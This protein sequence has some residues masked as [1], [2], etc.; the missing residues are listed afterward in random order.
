MWVLDFVAFRHGALK[1]SRHKT[2]IASMI[3]L[4]LSIVLIVVFALRDGGTAGASLGAVFLASKALSVGEV[5]IFYLVLWALRIPD[6][7]AWR[8]L[9]FALVMATVTRA[10]ALTLGYALTPGRPWLAVVF[11]IVTVVMALQFLLR[12]DRHEDVTEHWAVRFTK[13]LLPLSDRLPPRRYVLVEDGRRKGTLLLLAA[14][15]FAFSVVVFA[16]TAF[17]AAYAVTD[18]PVI[19]LGGGLLGLVGFRSL[20]FLVAKWGDVLGAVKPA[21]TLNFG[22]AG[23]ATLA[24]PWFRIDPRVTLAVL[25]VIWATACAAVW[26]AA[27]NRPAQIRTR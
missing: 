13:G 26:Y 10:L 14:L 5:F 16:V 1:A 11:G 15:V 27:H 17:P 25:F 23:L 20:Y 7:V 24:A 6:V 2:L 19:G 3:W 22:F 18:D 4:A 12:S 9:F 8:L 21:L